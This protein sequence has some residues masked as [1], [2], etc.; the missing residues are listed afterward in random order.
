MSVIGSASPR[1]RRP[2]GPARSGGRGQHRREPPPAVIHAADPAPTRQQ[3][4]KPSR[5][6]GDHVG[7]EP[8]EGRGQRRLHPGEALRTGQGEQFGGG[9]RLTEGEEGFRPALVPEGVFHGQRQ[10]GRL[11]CHL[12]QARDAGL[13][14]ERAGSHVGKAPL[15]RDPDRAVRRSQ[16]RAGGGQ[17]LRTA[18]H[19]V[20]I[21]G[22][23]AQPPEDAILLQHRRIDRRE[24][25]AP[26]KQAVGRHDQDRRIPPRRM[27][28]VDD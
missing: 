28:G 25:L 22:E 23:G 13:Q 6:A 27:I 2:G 4:F 15:R 17:K 12:G 7:G 3:R 10:E 1:N 18:P 8:V 14:P 19:A 26:R 5:I 11:G 16:D 21:D 20:E 9:E 24:A